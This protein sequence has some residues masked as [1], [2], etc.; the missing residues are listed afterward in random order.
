MLEDFRKSYERNGY[1]SPLRIIDPG[2]AAKHRA[3]M[4]DAE[5]RIGPLH[6]KFKAHTFLRSPFELA[7]DPAMLDLVEALLGPNILL[8]N[9]SYII[10]EP[11]TPTHVCWHQDLTYWGL[12]SDAQVSAWLALSPATPQ[13]GCMRMIPGSHKGGRCDHGA[14]DDEAN[15]LLEGQTVSGVDESQARLCPLGPGEASFHH[16]WTLH[17][18][19]PNESA[20]RRIGLN[21]QYLATDVHQTLHDH[22]SALLVRGVDNFGNFDADIPAVDDLDP[23]AVASQSAMQKR[24]Q[25]IYARAT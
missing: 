9:V 7:T 24:L 17:A 20:E 23:D 19:M 6:Y 11:H 10:K 22:D 13:N 1:V 16:G 12:S 18:S 2:E 8:Y 4:E 21:V 5:T 3:A 25:A 15:I 14:S